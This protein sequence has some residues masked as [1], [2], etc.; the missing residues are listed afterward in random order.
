MKKFLALILSVAAFAFAEPYTH[1]GFFIN[2]QY[3]A[4]LSKQETNRFDGNK[5]ESDNDFSQELVVK[6]GGALNQTVVLHG[7]FWFSV[8]RND[9]NVYTDNGDWNSTARITVLSCI[10]G[11]GV[12]IYPFHYG[13]MSN[14]FFSGTVGFAVFTSDDDDD[15]W[16]RYN[17]ESFSATG[18]G[19]DLEVGKEWWVGENWS[20]GIALS[21]NLI[22]ADD[23][24]YSNVKWTS[25]SFHVRFTAS[26]S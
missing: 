6:V 9:F 25:N 5:I 8:G 3:G 23:D 16:L 15:D 13:V 17:Y 1:V 2:R 10:L 4:G 12:T 14:L 19:I 22:V 24:D 11:P 26:R 21:Y 20:L 18:V 7:A